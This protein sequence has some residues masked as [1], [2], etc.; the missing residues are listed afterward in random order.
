MD[1][2]NLTTGQQLLR[3]SHYNFAV[4]GQYDHGPLFFSADLQLAG[5]RTDFVGFDL[6]TVGGYTLVN[7]GVGYQWAQ[8]WSMQLRLDNALDRHYE[9]VSGYNT[10]GRSVTLA[11]RFH[12]R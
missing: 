12:M 11:M 10:A 5:P 2:Q 3:R 9:L 6:G 1:P 7:L 4:G 8:H